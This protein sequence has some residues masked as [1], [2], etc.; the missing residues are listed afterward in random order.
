MS[1]EGLL[2]TGFVVWTLVTVAIYVVYRLDARGKRDTWKRIAEERRK[3]WAARRMLERYKRDRRY[4]DDMAE[5]ADYLRD[6]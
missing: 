2:T 4:P 1:A 3:L 6:R 5:L